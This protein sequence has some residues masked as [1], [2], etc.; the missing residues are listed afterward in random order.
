MGSIPTR[1]RLIVVTSPFAPIIFFHSKMNNELHN[2]QASAIEYFLSFILDGVLENVNQ[3][4][5]T[6][7]YA[8]NVAQTG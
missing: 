3:L 7:V 6:L 1:M 4:L 2:H 8:K 5:L